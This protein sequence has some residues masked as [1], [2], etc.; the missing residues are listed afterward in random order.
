[1][2][3]DGGGFVR[4][5][6]LKIDHLEDKNSTERYI[7]TPKWKFQHH[8]DW[9]T[10]IKYVSDMNCVIAG[11]LDRRISITDAEDRTPLKFLEGHEKGVLCIDWSPLYKVRKTFIG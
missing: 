6:E 9:V 1:M 11:S 3:G 8:S 7:D 4:L 2:F 5:Y 10:C